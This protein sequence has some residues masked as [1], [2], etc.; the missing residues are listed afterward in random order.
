VKGRSRKD[1]GT[2][3]KRRPKS[4]DRQKLANQQGTRWAE[5]WTNPIDYAGPDG[6]EPRPR[7]AVPAQQRMTELLIGRDQRPSI[8]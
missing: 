4:K 7:C 1:K 6:T 3:A 2:K 5:F 8:G